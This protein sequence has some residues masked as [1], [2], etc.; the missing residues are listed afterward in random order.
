MYSGVGRTPFQPAT[1]A[2]L[3][4]AENETLVKQIIAIQ[5]ENKLC[6]EQKWAHMCFR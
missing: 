4:L 2:V 5:T 6:I 3:S 1:Q